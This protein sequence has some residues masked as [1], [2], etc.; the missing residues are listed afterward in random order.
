MEV[1]N[2][3]WSEDELFKMRSEVLS[4]WPTGSDVDI[5]EAID[6]RKQLPLSKSRIELDRRAQKEGRPYVIKPIGRA[7]VED[8]IEHMQVLIEA[9]IQCFS[10]FQD[11]YTRKGDYER[12]QIG[13]EESRKQGFSM[14]NG[15]PIVNYGVRAS[16]KVV[17][18][19]DVPIHHWGATDEDPRPPQE[20]GMAAGFASTG[21]HNVHDLIQHSRN[22]PLVECSR[23]SP[24]L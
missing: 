19:I 14:L 2:K 3:R 13:I 24:K 20:I 6:Y 4:K 1:R 16:R 17:E 9:G 7:L 21:Y 23:N 10:L 11:T 12:A 18:T 5:D 22:Y 8:L 15:Y